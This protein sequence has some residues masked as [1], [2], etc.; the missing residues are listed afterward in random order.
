[1]T[2]SPYLAVTVVYQDLPDLIEIE[3]RVDAGEWRG[4]G[5]A[6]TGPS[7]LFEQATCL[8]SWSHLPESEFVLEA[9]VDTGLLRLRWYPVDAAGHL[10][11]QVELMSCDHM[12]N[13]VTDPWRLSIVIFTEPGLVERFAR[14]LASI[15][16]VA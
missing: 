4:V 5:R 6:Y 11:C 15:V 7:R 9:G 16:A 12:S 8:E 13:R 10:A 1:M 3:V 14:H 2:T